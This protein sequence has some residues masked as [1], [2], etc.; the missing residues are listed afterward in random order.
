[1]ESAPSKLDR[2]LEFLNLYTYDTVGKYEHIRS[3][4]EN[5]NLFYVTFFISRV[6]NEYWLDNLTAKLI[7]EEFKLCEDNIDELINRLASIENVHE[8]A[9]KLNTDIAN[10][11]F[12]LSTFWPLAKVEPNANK[13]KRFSSA[14]SL[15]AAFSR[16]KH[17][18]ELGEIFTLLDEPEADILHAALTCDMAGLD[19]ASKTIKKEFSRRKFLSENELYQ[20][21]DTSVAAENY[22]KRATSAAA[23]A[24]NDSRHAINR[25]LRAEAV[26]L[27]QNGKFQSPR[28]A[29]RQL[30]PQV[31][32]I[33]E[34]LGSQLE[35]HTN[36]FDRLYKWLLAAEKSE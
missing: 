15:S 31:A 11:F 5:P 20:L 35:W 27:Y 8:K 4:K 24:G 25:T 34:K 19:K 22:K 21:L 28:Y 32:A 3:S 9:E 10:I 26:K 1:M 18:D 17:F 13:L 30:L 29:A 7:G 14:K 2:A 16:H 23:K 36:G 6:C 12:E 33:S